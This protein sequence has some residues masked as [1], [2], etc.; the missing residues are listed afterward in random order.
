MVHFYSQKVKKKKPSGKADF[1]DVKISMRIKS[2]EKRLHYH[3]QHT[4][5]T[6]MNT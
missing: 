3:D 5:N 4:T 2:V 1:L 6:K